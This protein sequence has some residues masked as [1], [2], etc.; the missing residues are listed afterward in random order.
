MPTKAQAKTAIDAAIVDLKAD[1][2]TI[3]PT[4]V[5]IKDGQISFGPT[6]YAIELDAGGSGATALSWMNSITAA[7][8]TAGR[9]FTLKRGD[10]R[11]SDENPV[12]DR[13]KQVLIIEAKLTVVIRNF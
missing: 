13:P 12:A 3:L 9:T 11:V 8:T 2:D 10:R 7:L 6:R 5:N 1:I 4:G